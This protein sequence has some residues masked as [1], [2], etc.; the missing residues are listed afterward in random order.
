MFNFFAA[1]F[2]L[3]ENITF[4]FEKTPFLCRKYEFYLY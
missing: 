4:V 1:V 2:Q 3:Y